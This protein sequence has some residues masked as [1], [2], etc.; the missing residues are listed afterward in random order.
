[1]PQGTGLFGYDWAG[2]TIPTQYLPSH[3]ARARAQRLGASLRRD[4]GSGQPYY[5][6]KTGGITHEVWFEDTK[7]FAQKLALVEEHQLRGVAIWRL[8]FEEPDLWDHISEL[9]G[10]R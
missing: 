9:M 10:H 6:Y 3:S 1:M 7:S 4:E 8:G 2:A 5:T